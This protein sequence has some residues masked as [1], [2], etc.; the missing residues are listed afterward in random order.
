MSYI[1]FLDESGHDHRTMPYEARGGI[2]LH[3][4]KLWPC[5]QGVQRLELTSFGTARHQIRIE[6]K[7]S[8]SLDKDRFKWANQSG[9][10]PDEERR[11]HCRGFLIRGLEK[12]SPGRAE[13]TACGQACLE[14]AR[15]CSIC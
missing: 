9:P 12:E 2:A 10:M 5:A 7:G 14:M 3:A 1:L 4:S 11:K 8:E 6:L 13:F 15:E